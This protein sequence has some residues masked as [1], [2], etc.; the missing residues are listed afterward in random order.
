M[1]KIHNTTKDKILKFLLS[2]NKEEF[3]I[4]SI[5]KKI[6]VDYKSVYLAI[7][8]LD[9]IISRKAGQTVLC[10]INQKCYDI[11]IIMAEFI[12]KEELLSN[13][14]IYVLYKRMKEDIK[15]PFFVLLLFGSYA[16]GKTRKGSDIDLM[17]ITDDE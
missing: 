16:S 12:R 13:K 5:S 9:V 11:N 10:K 6:D 2:N 14:D 17:L 4:R 3:T 8:D 15:G 7:K 1:E